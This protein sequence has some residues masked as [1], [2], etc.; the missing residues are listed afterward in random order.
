VSRYCTLLSGLNWSPATQPIRPMS[1]GWVRRNNRHGVGL[2]C[3]APKCRGPVRRLT[4]RLRRRAAASRR[5]PGLSLVATDPDP[6][7][8]L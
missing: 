5:A 6:V 2:G 4:V 1:A 7:S 3:S 8:A